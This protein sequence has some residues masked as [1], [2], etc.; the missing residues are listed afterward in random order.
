MEMDNRIVLYCI[1]LETVWCGVVWIPPQLA[2]RAEV[3]RLRIF[4]RIRIFCFFFFVLLFIIKITG[5]QNR[6]LEI[7]CDV[8]SQ[9]DR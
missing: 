9:L 3:F 6:K 2:K 5:Y 7:G 8:V 4:C 1:V